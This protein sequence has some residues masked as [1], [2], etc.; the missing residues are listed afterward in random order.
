MKHRFSILVALSIGLA[1]LAACGGATQPPP[2]NP[3]AAS[4]GPVVKPESGAA[5]SHLEKHVT[6][7][8]T[9]SAILAAC[10]N[11]TEFT[12]EEKRWFDQKLPDREYKSAAEAIAALGL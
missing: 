11:T 6:Y 3:S 10:A 9:R 1:A 12:A 4:D 5:R 2:A 8:A 7:P